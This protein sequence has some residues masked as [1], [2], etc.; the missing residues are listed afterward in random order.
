MEFYPFNYQEKRK[1]WPGR[2]APSGYCSFRSIISPERTLTNLNP[3]EM[4]FSIV[5]AIIGLVS[6]GLM[7]FLR[8]ELTDILKGLPETSP[9]VEKINK[10]LKRNLYLIVFIVVANTPNWVSLLFFQLPDYLK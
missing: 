1:L 2:S 4:I 6:T 3:P 8:K 5:V 9:L 7:L 10:E